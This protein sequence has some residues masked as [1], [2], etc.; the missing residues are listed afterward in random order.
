MTEWQ[1]GG[2]HTRILPRLKL[3]RTVF[4]GYSVFK[5][6]DSVWIHN[7]MTGWFWV[8]CKPVLVC[9]LLGIRHKG[10]TIISVLSYL[11]GSIR[12]PVFKRMDSVLIH[13]G[14]I[15]TGVRHSWMFLSGVHVFY[16]IVFRLNLSSNGLIGEPWRNDRLV[17]V[18]PEWFYEELNRFFKN[19]KKKGDL[20]INSSLP[21]CTFTKIYYILFS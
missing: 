12:Y 9:F 11:K 16:T 13:N 21:L 10:M 7:G 18:S 4:I 5:N 3:S 1:A 20:N 19:D 17:V 8:P 2:C 15:I 6:L 14:M